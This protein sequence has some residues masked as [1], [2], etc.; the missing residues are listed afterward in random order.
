MN[1]SNTWVDDH[2][3]KVLWIVKI[4]MHFFI[5]VERVNL[6]SK[7]LNENLTSLRFLPYRNNR[8]VN[9]FGAFNIWCQL[10]FILIQRTTDY[11]KLE[12][13]H[14]ELLSFLLVKNAITFWFLHKQAFPYFVTYLNSFKIFAHTFLNKITFYNTLFLELIKDL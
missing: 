1:H 4:W 9:L 5:I 10:V 14:Q 8:F 11:Q 12:N 6:K 2:I 13:F 3:N 7:R